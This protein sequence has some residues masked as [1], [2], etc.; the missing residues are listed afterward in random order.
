[1]FSHFFSR[2]EQFRTCSLQ[3]WFRHLWHKVT[4]QRSGFCSLVLMWFCNIVSPIVNCNFDHSISNKRLNVKTYPFVPGD[5]KWA[6]CGA[7]LCPA[8]FQ[9]ESSELP[10]LC[11]IQTLRDREPADRATAVPASSSG[12]DL[13]S[14]TQLW[15]S[16]HHPRQ[17][18][19]CLHQSWLVLLTVPRPGGTAG[20]Q[21]HSCSGQWRFLVLNTSY[22]LIVVLNYDMVYFL[23]TNNEIK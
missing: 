2:F 10:G 8:V 13:A 16:S 19:R 20:S 17:G 23:A 7:D 5:C 18:S 3:T 21:S 14:C 15:R 11:S 9:R 1:M 12:D 22:F 4:S 6:S